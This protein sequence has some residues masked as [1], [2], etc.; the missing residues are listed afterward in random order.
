MN[1]QYLNQLNK[2]IPLLSN[3]YQKLLF[4]HESKSGDTLKYFS[5]SKGY[6][7]INLNL[8]LSEK[9]RKVKLENRPFKAVDLMDELIEQYDNIICIDYIEILYEP[10]LRLNAIEVLKN[11]S[12]RA[13]LLVAWRGEI[14]NGQLLHAR[15]GYSD[16]SKTS[17]DDIA[18]IY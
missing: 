11:L 15:A 7:Y 12:R 17:A 6:P 9:L 1:Y 16:Y 2:E 4:I 14:V 18:I 10:T 13:I 8:Y 3:K 5:K